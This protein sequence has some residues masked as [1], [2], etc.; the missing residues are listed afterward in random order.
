MAAQLD[1]SQFAPPR[2]RL[3]FRLIFTATFLVFLAAAV[4]ARCLPWRWLP[5]TQ[6]RPRSL[7]D[8]ARAAANTFIPF[9]FM[10]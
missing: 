4:V 10:G 2:A 5:F 3:E 8:E 1:R 6:D 9:A 7:I